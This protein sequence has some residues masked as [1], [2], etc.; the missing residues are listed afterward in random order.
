[1][2]QGSNVAIRAIFS[3][4]LA[5]TLVVPLDIEQSYEH[6]CRDLWIA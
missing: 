2:V 1:L 5:E 3:L 6:A 4:W